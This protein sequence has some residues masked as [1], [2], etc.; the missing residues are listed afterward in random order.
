MCY[1][2]FCTSL[3]HLLFISWR[4]GCFRRNP[5]SSSKSRQ[6]IPAGEVW[7][8]PS[9][10]DGGNVNWLSHGGEWLQRFLKKLQVELPCD[11]AVPLLGIYLEK[12]ETLI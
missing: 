9:H 5:A 7:R 6:I 8:K 4:P 2:L 12:M 11:P 1:I 10:T 3:F